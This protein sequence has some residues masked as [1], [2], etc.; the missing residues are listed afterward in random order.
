MS[1][2]T[3]SQSRGAPGESE[4]GRLCPRAWESLRNRWKLAPQELRV[5]QMLFECRS[6]PSMAEALDISQY[7]V[8]SYFR[9]LYRKAGV[10]SQL[11]EPVGAGPSRRLGNRARLSP[12]PR[13]TPLSPP[14]EMWRMN[15]WRANAWRANT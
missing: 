1:N 5:L 13:R 14:P 10:T 8:D 7:T 9:R 3:G 15:R 12:R 11:D 4:S 2:P 6:R